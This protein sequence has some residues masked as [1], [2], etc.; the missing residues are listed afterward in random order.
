MKAA[1]QA[2][3]ENAAVCANA[4]IEA[5]NIKY[6]PGDPIEKVIWVNLYASQQ[7]LSRVMIDIEQADC[8]ALG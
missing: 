4:D 8:S 6:R 2:P 1:W 5:T 3:E 7:V